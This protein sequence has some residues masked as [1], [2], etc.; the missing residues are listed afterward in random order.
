MQVKAYGKINLYLDILDRRADGF[1]NIETIFQT[2]NLH[3]TLTFEVRDRDL[4]MTCSDPSLENGDSNLVLCAAKLLQDRTGCDKGIHVHL[5]KRI[6]VAGG[7]A[8]GSVDAAATLR[9]LNKLWNLELDDAALH[10]CAA[11]LGSDVPYCLIGGTVAATGRGEILEPINPLPETWFVLVQ[12]PLGISAGEVYNHSALTR[13]EEKSINERTPSFTRALE[14]L[15][16]GRIADVMF[17]QMESAILTMHPELAELKTHML[18]MGCAAAIVSGSGPTLV[19]FCENEPAT[20]QVSGSLSE[21]P[22][23]VVNST[24]QSIMV[25]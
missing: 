24:V 17:N 18:N 6:P 20:E 4:T 13:N 12:P 21:A 11:E 5:E 9:A 23:R 14:L 10:E 2:V 19:G 1:N 16:E 15:H 8:G 25:D 3:D 22:V 7:M